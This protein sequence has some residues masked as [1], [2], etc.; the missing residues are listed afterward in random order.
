[1]VRLEEYLDRVIRSRKRFREKFQF[2]YGS[3]RRKVE[4]STFR[5]RR[6]SLFQFQYGSIRSRIRVKTVLLIVSFQQFQFQYGSIIEVPQLTQ[7]YK[8]ADTLIITD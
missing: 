7:G 4:N 6:E 5:K 3:I 2:Q 1:M 8:E